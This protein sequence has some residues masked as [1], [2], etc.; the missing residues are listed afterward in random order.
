[1]ADVQQQL[2][3]LLG[4]KVKQIRK[5]DETPSRISVIDVVAS[6][7]HKNQ[8]DAG[9][10]FRRVLEQ[11][12]DVGTNCSYVKFPDSRGRKGQK[13]TPVANV[14]GIIEI[15]MLL[16]GRQA[17]SVRWQASELLCRWLGGDLSLVEEV[18]R[19]R[20]FQE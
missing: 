9:Q 12:P 5:T 15:I 2:A 20:G 4:R 3:T 8:H 18:C 13:D 14:R 10:D 19:N 7:A 17:T 16:P 1:M 6:I 11:Y